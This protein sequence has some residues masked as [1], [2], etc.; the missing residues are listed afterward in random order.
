MRRQLLKMLNKNA[1]VSLADLATALGAD[2]AAVAAEI[3]A[4][5]DEGIL[6]GY[7][8]VIDW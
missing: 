1:R 8:A 6:R 5:E 7:K 3:K 4:L 2:E